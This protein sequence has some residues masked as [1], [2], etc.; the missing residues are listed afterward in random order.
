MPP[1][2]PIVIPD[3]RSNYGWW[4]ALAVG[5]VLVTVLVALLTL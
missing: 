2:E 5:L 4:I 1:P 3:E